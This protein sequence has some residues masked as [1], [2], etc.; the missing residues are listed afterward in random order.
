MTRSGALSHRHDLALALRDARRRT[1][2]LTDDL[3]DAEWLGPRLSI[4]NPLLWLPGMTGRILHGAETFSFASATSQSRAS[5]PRSRA[6]AT[7]AGR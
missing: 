4:V 7:G 2:E 5:Q 3:S 1:L 6:M